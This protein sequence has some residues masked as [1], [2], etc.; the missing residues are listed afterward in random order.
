MTFTRAR[1]KHALAAGA[2]LGAAVLPAMGVPA[3]ASSHPA[4]HSNTGHSGTGHSGTGHSSTGRQVTYRGYHFQVPTGW[5][6]TAVHPASCVRFDR[7]VFYLGGPGTK[8]SCPSGLVGTTEAVLVQPSGAHQ[9]TRSVEDPVAHRI[10]VTAPRLTVTATYQANERQILAI[11]ASAGLPAPVIQNPAAMAPRS[12]P[13]AGVPRRVT[14]FTGRGFDACTAP[15]PQAMQA[16]LAHSRYQAVGIYIGGS[17]VA[18]AQPNLTAAWVSQQAAAGWHFIPLYV[19]PQVGF[20]GEVTLPAVQAT[21]AAQD[22]VVQARLLGFRRGTPI[23]YDMEAYPARRSLIALEFF[24]AWTTEVHLL[25]YRSGIY[26][27]SDSGV[28]DLVDNYANPTL[29]MPDVIFD[30]WWN[31]VANT[32]DPNI[33]ALDWVGHRR[34]HQYAGNVTQ[35]HGGVQINIDRDFLDVHF[36]RRGWVAGTR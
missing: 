23:Y 19:G 4:V 14:N 12:A 3:G 22:A 8:Q 34:V 24:T 33:P 5:P 21:A 36:R 17:D 16:W 35:T 26:S 7:H 29:T 10:T 25:G 2:A 9:A 31:G 13:V 30:A 32:F 15:D 27:S 1:H 28:T 11:L 6:A 20:R 18:C